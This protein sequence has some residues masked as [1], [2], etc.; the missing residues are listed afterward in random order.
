[1]IYVCWPPAYDVLKV[2]FHEIFTY[3]LELNGTSPQSRQLPRCLL[4]R[5][6]ST[7]PRLPFPRLV[8]PMPDLSTSERT[9]PIRVTREIFV[10]PATPSIPQEPGFERSWI[11]AAEISGVSGKYG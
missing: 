10:E 9:L 11:P 2:C 1:M 3:T 4:L 5:P 6:L 8:V 7:L